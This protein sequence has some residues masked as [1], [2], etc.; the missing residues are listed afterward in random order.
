MYTDYHAELYYLATP[1]GGKSG[2]HEG[3]NVSYSGFPTEIDIQMSG[4][5]HK[6]EFGSISNLT[7]PHSPAH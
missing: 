2:S 6:R 4:S 1:R 3:G 7:F 5:D